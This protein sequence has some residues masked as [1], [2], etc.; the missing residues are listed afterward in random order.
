M[1]RIDASGDISDEDM[2]ILTKSIQT[3]AEAAQDVQSQ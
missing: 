2:E 3:Y 1:T